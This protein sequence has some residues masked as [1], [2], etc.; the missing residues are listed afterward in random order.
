MGKKRKKKSIWSRLRE[1]CQTIISIALVAGLASGAFAYFA[2]AADL[3]L[4]A[5]RFQQKL[6]YDRKWLL[7]EELIRYHRIYGENPKDPVIKEKIERLKIQI[8]DIE[9]KLE[10][11]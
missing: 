3:Q 4:L 5:E 9:K 7:Q 11:K 2:K 6:D 1:Q 10:P 8:K